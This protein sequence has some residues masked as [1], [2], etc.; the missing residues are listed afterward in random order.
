MKIFIST[1]GMAMVAL[2]AIIILLPSPGVV[3]PPDRSVTAV[4]MPCKKTAVCHDSQP[5]IVNEEEDLLEELA[6]QLRQTATHRPSKPAGTNSRQ[7]WK[8]NKIEMRG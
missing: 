5:A 3:Q 8:R 6:C 1:I 4:D 7:P 2:I